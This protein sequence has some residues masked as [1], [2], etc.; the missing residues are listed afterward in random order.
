MIV[1]FGVPTNI[2]LAI[3]ISIVIAT[4]QRDPAWRSCTRCSWVTRDRI[5]A[6]IGSDLDSALALL[7]GRRAGPL[8][9]R[10]DHHRAGDRA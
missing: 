10:S 8:G 3:L 2:A 4:K 7:Y 9:R 6:D 5:A 1:S